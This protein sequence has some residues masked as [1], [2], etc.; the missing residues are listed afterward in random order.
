[1]T[2]F[3][4]SRLLSKVL[5]IFSLLMLLT[6]NLMAQFCLGLNVRPDDANPE[7]IFLDLT[8]EE[9]IGVASMQFSIIYDPTAYEIIGLAESNLSD[10]SDGSYSIRGGNN[11]GVLV[12]A[13]FDIA[14]VGVTFEEDK[15]LVSFKFKK[16]KESEATFDFAEDPTVI[17][18]SICPDGIN[19]ACD[20]LFNFENCNTGQNLVPAIS[21]RLFLDENQDCIL[22][23]EEKG[24]GLKNWNGWTVS[25]SQNGQYYFS[26]YLKEDGSYQLKIFP[27]VNTIEITRP[28]PY[29]GICQSSFTIHSDEID[30]ENDFFESLIQIT[31]ECPFLE[32]SLANLSSY[33]QSDCETGLYILGYGNNGTADATDVY[34]DLNMDYRVAIKTIDED[35]LDLGNKLYSAASQ[36]RKRDF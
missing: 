5:S 29:Y 23:E 12:L 10:F 17:E 32:V 6:S 9:F 21:G 4:Q 34:I 18:V 35:Y 33:A 16:L 30:T 7:E 26:G 3:T 36:P 31:E 22:T 15:P 24:N 2:I 28:G 25:A 27:G 19:G 20:V 8:T 14:A 11:S 1:M 13:W